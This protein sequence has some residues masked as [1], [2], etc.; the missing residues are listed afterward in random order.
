MKKLIP[1][2]LFA[3]ITLNIPDDEIKIVENDVISADQWIRD[4]W[5][6]KLAKSK[7]RIV[8]AEVSRSVSR[9]EAVPA[10]EAAIISQF[11]AR[12][13]YKNRKE[14]DDAIKGR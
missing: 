12:P 14:R 1:F 7:A 13:G 11:L 3:V 8:E 10:G 6:G 4:A 2:F 9:G 5:A